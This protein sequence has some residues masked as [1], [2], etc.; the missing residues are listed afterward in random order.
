MKIATIIYAATLASAVQGAQ[1]TSII[2]NT[3]YLPTAGGLSVTAIAP[4]ASFSTNPGTQLGP[5]GFLTDLAA[6][7]SNLDIAAVPGPSIAAAA[8]IA[9]TAGAGSSF[10][11]VQASAISGVARVTNNTAN[12]INAQAQLAQV[13]DIVVNGPDTASLTYL[14]LVERFN[15]QTSSWTSV[16]TFNN[17]YVQGQS[18][19]TCLATQGCLDTYSIGTIG[20]NSSAD[21]RVTASLQAQAAQGGTSVPEPGTFS[22]SLLAAAGIWCV[23]GRRQGR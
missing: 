11:G 14:L 8:R 2:S 10:A 12:S 1:I 18:N 15:Q 5:N 16:I 9:L 21:Y 17:T 7:S 4:N 13:I 19:R 20:A 3:L 23:R 6:S 22:L